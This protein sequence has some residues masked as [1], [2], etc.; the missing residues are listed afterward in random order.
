MHTY[1]W[2][3]VRW[4][5]RE[6]VCKW[7][8]VYVKEASDKEPHERE[9]QSQGRVSYHLACSSPGNSVLS[10]WLL[11]N[12]PS[13]DISHFL[14]TIFLTAH[15][16]FHAI[17]CHDGMGKPQRLLR[18][19]A[20]SNAACCSA[21]K[22]CSPTQTL[23]LVHFSL[24]LHNSDFKS[25]QYVVPWGNLDGGGDCVRRIVKVSKYAL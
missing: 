10:K 11:I 23:P 22:V 25:H 24:T 16:L 9:M 6:K 21:L 17:F 20:N 4:W 3:W 15:Q 13:R 2:L 5:A 8:S 18:Y 19:S 14:H 12:A 7:G 1:P